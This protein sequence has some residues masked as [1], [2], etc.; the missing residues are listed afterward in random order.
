M[1]QNK[2]PYII[3]FLRSFVTQ[4]RLVLCRQNPDIYLLHIINISWS[5][6]KEY[7]QIYTLLFW[8]IF[9]K[10]YTTIILKTFN[11]LYRW[12]DNPDTI[13]VT[14]HHHSI[15]TMISWVILPICEQSSRCVYCDYWQTNKSF[16]VNC[17]VINT[18]LNKIKSVINKSECIM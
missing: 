13:E 2:F 8:K 12:Q 5:I 14:F 9:S 4:R 17:L 18:N 7:C 6:H 3:Y 16:H 10:K 1:N 11:M 15:Y